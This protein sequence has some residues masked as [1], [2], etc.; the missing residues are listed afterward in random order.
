MLNKLLP[1][2]QESGGVIRTV[3]PEQHHHHTW[4]TELSWDKTP[5]VKTDSFPNSGSLW[6]S[7]LFSTPDRCPGSRG[8]SPMNSVARGPLVW[9]V[10]GSCGWWLARVAR[11]PVI[12]VIPAIPVIPVI[13]IISVIS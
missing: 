1:E 10:A 6:G 8:D 2:T 3:S 9:L 13:P 12:P 7:N 5:L 4:T 11:G